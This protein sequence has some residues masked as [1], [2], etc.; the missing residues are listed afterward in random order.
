MRILAAV[1]FVVGVGA[2]GVSAQ[3]PPSAAPDWMSGYWLSCDG[4]RETAESWIGAGTGT[5]LGT[6]LSGGG[7]EFFAHRAERCGWAELFLDAERRIAADGV[8]DDEQFRSARG[9]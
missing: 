3:A 9:V 6:N 5:L 1:S 7:F 8:R 2:C 4:G